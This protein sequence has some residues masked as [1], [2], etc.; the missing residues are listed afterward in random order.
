MIIFGNAL[1]NTG[2]H[3]STDS[4]WQQA[5]AEHRAEI[6]WARDI[7][8]STSACLIHLLDSNALPGP[9]AKATARELLFRLEELSH[10][11]K[12]WHSRRTEHGKETN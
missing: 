12:R 1:G 10:W 6:N 8:E 9:L 5:E 3:L 4:P 11:A 2:D 7:E